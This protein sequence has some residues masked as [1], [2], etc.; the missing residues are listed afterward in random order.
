[1]PPL[2]LAYISDRIL[3]RGPLSQT[4]AEFV[5]IRSQWQNPSDILTILTI[6]GG[7]IIQGALAQIVSSHPR[8][9]T[10]IAFSFGWVAYSFT[11]VLQAV[12]SRRLLPDPDC[13]CVLI[14]AG[15]GYP[16]NVKSWALS[17]LVRDYEL[18]QGEASGLTVAFFKTLPNKQTGIPDRDWVY[19]TG[20]LVILLQ[21]GIATIPGALYS[22][23]AILLITCGG[24]LLVQIQAALPQWR[25][26]LWAAR[27]VD[28]GKQELVCLT[29]GNGTPYVLVIKSEGC[30]LRLIDL[31]GG[32]EIRSSITVPLTCMMAVLWLVHLLT[33]QGVDNNSWYLL[34]IGA[35]GMVQNAVASGARRQPSA[36]GFHLDAYKTVHRKKAWDTLI[37]AEAVERNVGLSLVDTFFPGRLRPEEKKW[38]QEKEAEYAKEKR[39]M[40]P[41]CGEEHDLPTPGRE[42]NADGHLDFS[43]RTDLLI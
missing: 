30:G 20:G 7:D 18:P 4:A 3:P 15:S 19:Y 12:G 28:K 2:L 13:A 39:E 8:P 27:K 33:V 36:I 6:I 22:N 41:D 29:R 23:W 21:L 32:R 31:A 26:E 16:R 34:A 5:S 42:E 9:F 10:P 14:D 38:V 17:R 40:A 1:M 24:T 25:Q 43:N 37:A 11:A 35:L